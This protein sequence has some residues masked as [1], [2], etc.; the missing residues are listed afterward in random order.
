M[1]IESITIIEPGTNTQVVQSYDLP[2][3][4]GY[5]F[6]RRADGAQFENGTWQVVISAEFGGSSGTYAG[7][8]DVGPS[9]PTAPKAAPIETDTP[10][11]GTKGQAA[12]VEPDVN[13][14]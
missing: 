6:T 1:T 13:T 5:V 9:V 11:H 12:A 8:I 7:R 14:E 3:S 4:T 2:F 10:I